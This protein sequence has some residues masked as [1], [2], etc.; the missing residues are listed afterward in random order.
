[1][2]NHA[3]LAQFCK[4]HHVGLVVVGPEAPLAAGKVVFISVFHSGIKIFQCF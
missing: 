1:M 4:D 2:S 3:I